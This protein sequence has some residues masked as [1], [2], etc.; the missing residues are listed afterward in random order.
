MRPGQWMY[1][2]HALLHPGVRLQ[3]RVVWLGQLAVNFLAVSSVVFSV[4]SYWLGERN[5][6]LHNILCLVLLC[7]RYGILFTLLFG[8]EIWR[9]SPRCSLLI[10]R[11]FSIARSR[12]SEA[13]SEPYLSSPFERDKGNFET[14]VW[15]KFLIVFRNPM[16][17]NA[18]SIQLACGSKREAAKTSN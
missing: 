10:S 9:L 13:S 3:W 18:K 8:I 12:Y 11:E 6:G 1:F 4:R 2:R 14:V 17:S 5:E 15:S 16:W 7:L